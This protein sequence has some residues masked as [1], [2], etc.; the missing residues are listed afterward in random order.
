MSARIPGPARRVRSSIGELR[1]NITHLQAR[2]LRPRSFAAP[3]GAPGGTETRAPARAPARGKTGEGPRPR[4][5]VPERGPPGAEEGDLAHAPG[6]GHLHRRRPGHRRRDDLL[7]FRAGRRVL[8][9]RPERV[10]ELRRSPM[11]ETPIQDSDEAAP[12]AGGAAGT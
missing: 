7:R 2:V 10:H 6:A 1:R 5:P 3:G 4:P 9:V 8:Q 12:E 11:N